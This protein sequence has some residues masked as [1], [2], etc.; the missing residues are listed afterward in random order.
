MSDNISSDLNDAIHNQGG[1]GV[2][3]GGTGSDSQ[4]YIHH[5]AARS[6]NDAPTTV[7]NADSKSSHLMA[8]LNMSVFHATEVF[9]GVLGMYGSEASKVCKFISIQV[10]VVANRF[11]FYYV[12]AYPVGTLLHQFMCRDNAALF[13]V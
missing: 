10:S 2:C 9:I 7:G 12:A 6:K 11:Y 13:Q 8:V 3:G 1:A 5:E 4:R